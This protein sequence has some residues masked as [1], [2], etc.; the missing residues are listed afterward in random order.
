[1]GQ[2]GSTPFM[3]L[4]GNPVAV[5]VTFLRFARPAILKLSGAIDLQPVLFQVRAAFSQ[6]KK[7]GRREWV[8]TRLAQGPSGE[9]V[10][11]KFPHQG[12][13]ILTS[14]V[15]A[16]GLV[17]LAEDVSHVAEGDMVDFLP[18]REVLS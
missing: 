10:A 9:L 18:F 17:E 13:G 12:S 2:V 14:M 15:A 6:K 4:P 5:M 7:I 16:D 8:R 3:G 1:M 11:E